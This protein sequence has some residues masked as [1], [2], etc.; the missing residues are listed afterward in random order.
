MN[1]TQEDIARMQEQIDNIVWL[2]GWCLDR[3]QDCDAGA[4]ILEGLATLN[5][6]KSDLEWQVQ[7]A[8]MHLKKDEQ[9]GQV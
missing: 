3:T 1:Y 9:A 4:G 6:T 2:T 5:N 7:L 8:K